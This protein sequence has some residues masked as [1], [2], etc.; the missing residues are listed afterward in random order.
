MYFKFLG[1][2]VCY[3]NTNHYR[4]EKDHKEVV[5]RPSNAL[6]EGNYLNEL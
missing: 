5:L 1:K 6:N 2:D 3:S 4:T